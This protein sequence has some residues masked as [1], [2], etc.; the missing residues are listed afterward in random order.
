MDDIIEKSKEAKKRLAEHNRMK[1]LKRKEI[2]QN[3]SRLKTGRCFDDMKTKSKG[4]YLI[5]VL[6][7]AFVF[8]IMIVFPIFFMSYRLW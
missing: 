1:S 2:Q 8:V 3:S 4:L 5:V 7:E 6:Y